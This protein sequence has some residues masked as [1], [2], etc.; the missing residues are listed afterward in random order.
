MAAQRHLNTRRLSRP[1]HY[2]SLPGTLRITC[3]DLALVGYLLVLS[4]RCEFSYRVV[5]INFN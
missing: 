2:S 4:V 5:G 1:Y 3:D